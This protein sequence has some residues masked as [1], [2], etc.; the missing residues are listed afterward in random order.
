MDYL[1]ICIWLAVFGACAGSFLNVVISRL[2]QKGAFLSKARSHCPKCGAVIRSYDLIPV[3]SF[4][5]LK[6]RCRDCRRLISP[7]IPLVEL[8]GA[9]S[10]VVCFIYFGLTIR[11]ILAFGVIMI[12]LAVALIDLDTSEIP[13]SLIIALIPFAIGA[14]WGWPAIILLDRAIGFFAVSL[15][16]LLLAIV[17]P[18]AFGGGDIKLIA[19]C[20]FLL[21]WKNVV[22]AFFIAILLGGGYAV[23]LM[24]SRKRKRGDH[25]VFGPAL[26]TGIAAAM[27]FGGEIIAWYLNFFNISYRWW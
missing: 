23:F 20:G 21:G 15:P 25:M 12:L 5:L 22:L 24:L 13:H 16:L 3:L 11:L 14:I 17:I 8:A 10:A 18:G 7:R 19:V 4:I 9:L 1:I 27:F 6:G 2:P 26:C